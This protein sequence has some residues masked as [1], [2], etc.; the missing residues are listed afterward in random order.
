MHLK[1]IFCN[2]FRHFKQYLLIYLT[3]NHSYIIISTI[4][5]QSKYNQMKICKY[6]AK[7]DTILNNH[8]TICRYELLLIQNYTK[9][10]HKFSTVFVCYCK[11][12]FVNFLF[13]AKYLLS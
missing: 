8:I 3:Q 5:Q 2:M 7:I 6:T 12:F 4:V 1:S 11:L 13:V 9:F 10:C